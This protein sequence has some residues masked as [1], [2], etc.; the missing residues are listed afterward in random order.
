MAAQAFVFARFQPGPA[1]L[2]ARNIARTVKEY[3]L[4][5]APCQPPMRRD[6][7]LTVIVVSLQ[8]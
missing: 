4:P 2:P 6:K 5:G 8:H 1:P 7:R 3:R